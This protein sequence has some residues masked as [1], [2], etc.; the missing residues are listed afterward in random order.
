M[1]STPKPEASV[2]QNVVELAPVKTDK[3]IWEQRWGFQ[4][5][6]ADKTIDGV[7]VTKAA[8]EA[9]A[10]SDKSAMDLARAKAMIA[11]NAEDILANAL[12]SGFTHNGNLWHGDAIFQSQVQAFLLSYQVGLLQSTDTVEIRDKTNIIHHLSEI[13]LKSLAGALL[14]YVKTAYSTCWATKDSG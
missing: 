8:Q 4:D 1:F 10:L 9:I 13:E 2:T 3:N 5:K 6:F 11:K 14:T 12:S 7:L